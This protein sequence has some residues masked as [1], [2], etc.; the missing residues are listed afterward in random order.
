[1]PGFHSLQCLAPVADETAAGSTTAT[2]SDRS[3]GE[4]FS[5]SDCQ[6]THETCFVPLRGFAR[7]GCTGD[8]CLGGS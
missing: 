1:M 5:F 6:V 2:G 7:H 8:Q 4:C 3:G